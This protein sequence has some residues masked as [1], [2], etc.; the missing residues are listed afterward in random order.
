[1][2]DREPE[3][4]EPE[5]WESTAPGPFLRMERPRGVVEVWTLGEDRFAV[6]AYEKER[7][8]VGY[9]VAQQTADEFA[10]ELE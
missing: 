2:A 4:R 3:N 8:V 1:M 6:R 9:D 5:A 10:R 7:I